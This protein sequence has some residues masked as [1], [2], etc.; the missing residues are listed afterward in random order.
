MLLLIA[1]MMMLQEDIG[2]DRGDDDITGSLGVDSSDD[3]IT[4]CCRC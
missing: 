1:V 2:V 4:G 3:D